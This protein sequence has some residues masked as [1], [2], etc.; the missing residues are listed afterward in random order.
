MYREPNGPLLA[1]GLLS[2]ADVSLG[3]VVVSS[4]AACL[5]SEDVDEFLRKFHEGFK[6]K[7]SV[8]PAGKHPHTLHLQSTVPSPG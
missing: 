3:G 8:N 6:E 5:S 7:R 2:L 1:L 4:L